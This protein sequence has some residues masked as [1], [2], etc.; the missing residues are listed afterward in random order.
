MVKKFVL[1]G[2]CVS[3]MPLLAMAQSDVIASG[4]QASVTQADIEPLLKSLNPDGRTRLAADPGAMDQLVRSTL[5]QKTLLAEAKAK[6]WDKQPQVRTALEQAQ[7]DVVVR[8]YLAAVNAPPADYPSDA[9]IQSAYEQNQ[10]AFTAPRALHL[11]QIYLEAPSGSDAATLEKLRKQAGDLAGRAR[12]G[13]F[14]AL[15]KA[16][17]QDKT[18][19]ANGGDMGVVPE[20][21]LLPAIRQAA[22]ALKPGQVSAPVQTPTGFHVVKLID[23]KSATL[24]PLADVKEQIRT[25]LRAQR[26]Q[27][28][29]QAYVAKLAG[30]TPINEDALK[31]ALAAAQ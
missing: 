7:R 30:N 4:P 26:L 6:G 14:A 8:S 9:E 5:A 16:N 22:D 31:K 3:M 27:Q 20:T 29:V 1:A 24:R 11:A 10:A 13:D 18:S 25:T 2:W 12:G 19:A 17:S 28:N 15:A 21:M 23:V